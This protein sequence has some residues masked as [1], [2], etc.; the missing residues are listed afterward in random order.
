MLAGEGLGLGYG[1]AAACFAFPKAFD[2]GEDGDDFL[3][4]EGFTKG[5]H[6][7]LVAGDGE[8][9]AAVT[10]DAVEET[11]G[12]VPGVAVAVERGRRQGAVGVADV[13]VGLAFA[14]DAVAAGAIGHEESAS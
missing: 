9:G 8:F 2:V 5:G 10:D 3:V 6:D 4:A 11:V 12:V 13:P 14:V 7:G 1:D